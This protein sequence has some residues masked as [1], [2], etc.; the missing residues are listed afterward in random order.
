MDNKHILDDK[1][2]FEQLNKI[3]EETE[4]YLQELWEKLDND[5][6]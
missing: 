5:K 2:H 6:S 1:E 3:L 4:Q